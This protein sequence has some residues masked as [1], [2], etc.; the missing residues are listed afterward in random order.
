MKKFFRMVILIA[1]FIIGIY[2][3]NNI[4]TEESNIKYVG[5]IALYADLIDNDIDH[6]SVTHNKRDGFY[7]VIVTDTNYDKYIFEVTDE[8]KIE[9]KTIE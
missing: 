2:L 7:V 6:I 9:F 8:N 4:K 3:G 1:V 5:E